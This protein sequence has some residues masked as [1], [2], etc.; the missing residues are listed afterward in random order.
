MLA[1]LVNGVKGGKWFS[2]IDKVY[3]RET[4]E[5]AWSKVRA[6]QGASGVDRVSVERFMAQADKYLSE[7]AES[8]RDGSYR[9]EAV[10]RVE[11]DKGNGKKR[12][13]GIPTVKD[14]IVQTAVKMALE[15]IF[16]MKFLGSSYGFRPGMGAADAL[17]EVDGLLKSGKVYVVDA[18]LSSYFDSIPHE[19]LMERVK[20]SVSDGGIL[21]LLE[22][23][24]RQDIVSETARWKPTQ[25]TPQGAVISPLLANLY[26][27]G[28]DVHMSS[29]GFSMVRYADDFVVLCRSESEAL[30]ALG[31]VE[32][33]VAGNGLS[34]NADKTHIGDCRKAGGG[35]EFLGYYFEG[36]K[37]QIRK[38]SL[39]RLK[40]RIREETP[41]R[42]CGQ[43]I[44]AVVKGL[45][46][47][48]R[49]WFSYFKGASRGTVFSR[50]DE[51]IRSRIRAILR[52][53]G[54]KHG[55]GRTRADQ[56]KWNLT[57]FNDI[58]LFSLKTAHA[59]FRQSR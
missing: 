49:G 10:R 6:N 53:R 58:G 1:A 48:L 31:E 5:A 14:R 35:F 42:T 30:R 8:L 43:S 50:L 19:R 51:I 40:E 29:R 59:S 39:D 38:K 16:E 21:S 34:L 9:A 44:E 13:L 24:L 57:F 17:R 32:N 2:L 11:I 36:R 54:R 52:N 27:H 55:R 3:S 37:R 41:R 28:L 4:L 20:E 7:M 12:P 46:P 26:L 33:W 47:M 23:W 25:G 56:T 45:N 22:Q 18:D 15:P